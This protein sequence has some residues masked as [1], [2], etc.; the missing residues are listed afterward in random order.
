MI[1]N[2]AQFWRIIGV[3]HSKSNYLES[4]LT[5]NPTPKSHPELSQKISSLY[6]LL[7]NRTQEKRQAVMTETGQ[8][9]PYNDMINADSET[10]RL[11]SDEVMMISDSPITVEAEPSGS[12]IKKKSAKSIDDSK[13]MKRSIIKKAITNIPL[14]LIT[15]NLIDVPLLPFPNVSAK[16]WLMLELKDDFTHIFFP[17]KR[18]F[19]SSKLIQVGLEL[20]RTSKKTILITQP[21]FHP[22][23]Y[24]TEKY[25]QTIFIG[26]YAIKEEM[27]L[28][29]FK[30]VDGKLM[31]LENWER[32]TGNKIKNRSKGKIYYKTIDIE[33]EFE[34]HN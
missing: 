1:F 17:S 29:L 2:V 26:P 11:A 28:A 23:V 31:L 21:N 4:G 15:S 34:Y 10:V 27:N 3:I 12:A 6:E 32:R 18:K 30:R 33:S 8:E 24:A 9:M 7:T 16:L 19:L 25:E 13:Q 14:T 20:A 5:I 22:Q